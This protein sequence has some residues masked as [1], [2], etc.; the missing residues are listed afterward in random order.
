MIIFLYGED[1]FRSRQ[2]LSALKER[3]KKEVDKENS[4]LVLLDGA[5]LNMAKFN[6]AIGS[7]SL[8]ATKRMVVVERVFSAKNKVLGESVFE[9]LKKMPKENDN[10]II[11]WDEISGEK[12]SRNKLFNFL[13]GQEFS[14]NFK[15]YTI[16]QAAQWVKIEA[17]NKDAVFKPQALSAFI[18]MFGND[19]WSLNNAMDVLISYKEGLNKR[20]MSGGN[21]VELEEED[22]NQ[23]EGGNIDEN[24]FALT[25]AIAQKNKALALDLFEKEL[26]AGIAEVYLLHMITRQ[27]RILLQVRQG[28]DDGDTARKLSSRL[29]L[30]PF[31]VNK[32]Y[33]QVRNFEPRMLREIFSGLARIDMGIKTGKADL[34]TQ[35]SL[36]LV[37]I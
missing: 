34:K 35:I 1:T 19:L 17:Q 15:P 16:Q 9:Y 37:G 18:G 7:S 6:E 22:V 24:I 27:F 28:Y 25:D 29:N 5:E 26:D 33:Q 10:V 3:F 30:H 11:F 8:F 31:V 32:A 20:L 36:L 4:S 14:Q 13:A 12:M 21:K 23:L 2:K